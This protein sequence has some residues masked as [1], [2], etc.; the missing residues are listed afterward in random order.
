M[1]NTESSSVPQTMKAAYVHKNGDSTTA[2]VITV[3]EDLPV[4]EPKE[5]QI[6]VKVHA[7]AINPV[8]WKLIEGLFPGLKEGT[9]GSD[10]SGVIEKIGPNT[11]TEL[12]VGDEVYGDVIATMGSFG[13]YVLAK[14]HVLGKKPTNLSMAE[15]AALPLAGLTA[16]QGL[17]THG[18]LEK[19][20]KV[21]IFGGSGGV[22]SLAIQMAKA[23]GASEVTATGSSVDMIKG[24]GADVVVNYKE[25]NLMDAL[26]GQDFDMVYDTV[27][28]Y[29]HWEIAKASMKSTGHFVTIVG[30]GT[31][32]LTY[33]PKMLWRKMYGKVISGPQYSLFL[34]D[35]TPPAV[36]TDMQKMTELVESGS[37]K[38]VLDKSQYE[39]T[40]EGVLD[41]IKASKT[42]RAKGK[43]ILKVV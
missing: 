29:E 7:A 40:T 15:A 10:M 33:V 31:S 16:L 3:R 12:K 2:E 32:L 37:V 25:Q 17:T 41:M 34:T 14:A 8:D 18:N 36:V 4:P 13:E 27:G 21:L 6:L 39:L 20:H 35:T 26:K 9:V 23:M 1:S 30:D 42:H 24:F 5:G 28:G 38:P 19:G 22:G 11:T 43:L